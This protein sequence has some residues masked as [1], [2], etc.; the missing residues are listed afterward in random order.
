VPGQFSLIQRGLLSPVQVFSWSTLIAKLSESSSPQ[1]AD[2]VL[3]ATDQSCESVVLPWPVGN[4]WLED[5]SPA[6]PNEIACLDEIPTADLSSFLPP[7]GHND[8][9]CP[10]L[11]RC[12]IDHLFI[13]PAQSHA[14]TRDHHA[15]LFIFYHRL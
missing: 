7:G 13:P 6:F 5:D 12:S 4:T 8:G 9:T 10:F 14:S 3:S 11:W 2:F 1:A 15:L